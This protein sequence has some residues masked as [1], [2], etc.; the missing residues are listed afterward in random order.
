M[1]TVK[2]K[3]RKSS[4]A[5]KSG[6]IYYQLCYR[7]SY[8]QITTK[9]HI[10]PEAWDSSSE[11]IIIG[12][13]HVH[14]LQMYRIRIQR[15]VQLLRRI[16]HELEEYKWNYT[17]LDVVDAFHSNS[18]QVTVLEY[19]K[20]QIE[21]LQ[22]KKH[23]GTASNYK[24]ALSS[25]S[26]FLNH[27]DLSFGLVNE[28]LIQQYNDWLECRNMLKNSISFYMRIWRAIYNRAVREGIVEQSHPFRNVYTGIDRTRK[29]AVDED[30][31]LKLL[32]LDLNLSPALALSRDLFVFSYCARGMAFVDMA[33]LKKKDIEHNMLTY[34][35]RK[36]DQL[37]MVRIE[38]C[39]AYILQKYEVK[40]LHSKYV[41]PILTSEDDEK[42]FVQYHTALGYHNRKLKKLA[43][44]TGIPIRLSSYTSRH[45]WATAAR[46]H[47]VPLSVISAGMGHSSE[48]TTEIYL[49][50]LENSVIDDVNSGLLTKINRI[51]SF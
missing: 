31:I 32:E 48:K 51:I 5:G 6:T 18:S 47:N 26:T 23:Y 24:S 3:F 43:R 11:Q 9:M 33:F 20:R 38:P 42:A 16:I 7:Q 41:F 27:E 25:F 36:T 39:M 44:M 37:M 45:T 13:E 12:K 30:F 19:M 34:Y 46:R 35:R 10:P 21:R 4:V 1:T 50:S 17:L 40:T 22:K 28:G 14:T 49:A 8:K 15:D 2:V 29:R